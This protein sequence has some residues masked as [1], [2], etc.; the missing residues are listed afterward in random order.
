MDPGSYLLMTDDGVVGMDLRPG[1]K[2]PGGVN[3]D[4]ND[5]VSRRMSKDDLLDWLDRYHQQ[6][7][8]AKPPMPAKNVSVTRRRDK[9]NRV[10]QAIAALWPDRPPDQ[11][12]V[13]NPAFCRHVVDWLKTDCRNR[14]IKF[15]EVSNDTILRAARAAGRH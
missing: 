11:S 15:S 4:G 6:A 13:P 5:N 2:N 9:R 3:A 8:S 1:A 10:M 14:G 7:V 12:T